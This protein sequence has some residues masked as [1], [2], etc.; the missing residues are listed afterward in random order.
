MSKKIF[1]LIVALII[2]V[3][4]FVSA[5]LYYRSTYQ[6]PIVSTSGN[7]VKFRLIDGDSGKPI[8][9]KKIYVCDD[10]LKIDYEGEY[11]FPRFCDG[12]ERKT[13][14]ET[15]TDLYGIFYL[16]VK[17][18]NVK[19]P[20]GIVIDIGKTNNKLLT[21]GFERS[22]SLSHIFHPSYIRVLNMEKSSHVVSNRLYNLD[23]KE[24]KEIFTNGDPD[25]INTF[26]VIDLSIYR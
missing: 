24:V 5:V 15:E 22:N 4:A 25:K 20:N 14:S 17:N 26:D 1:F 13:I 7:G 10:S 8:S 6:P 9:N 2:M 18:I 21:V 11:P 19:P 12:K 23:T 16:D 3:V